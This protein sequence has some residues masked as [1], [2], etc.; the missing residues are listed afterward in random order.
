MVE[1]A[2]GELRGFHAAAND[3]TAFQDQATIAG[4]GKVRGSDQTIVARTG[5]DDIELIGHEP[6]ASKRVVLLN[7]MSTRRTVPAIRTGKELRGMVIVPS[8]GE[9]MSVS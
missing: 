1:A 5:N 7:A 6:H 9:E 3:G 8:Y 4:F 2:K